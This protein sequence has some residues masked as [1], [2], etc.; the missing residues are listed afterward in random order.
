VRN[1]GRAER[2]NSGDRMSDVRWRRQ[3]YWCVHSSIDVSGNRQCDKDLCTN[4]NLIECCVE[5]PAYEGRDRGLG[6][7]IKRATDALGIP[8]CGK[9]QKRRE[10]LNKMTEN[11]YGRKSDGSD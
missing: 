6:D 5:C 2:I 4:E 1:H 11:L 9:C 8:S 7:T 3:R 10:A